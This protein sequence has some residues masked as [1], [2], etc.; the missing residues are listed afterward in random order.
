MTNKRHVE[1]PFSCELVVMLSYAISASVGILFVLHTY[2]IMNNYS[3]IECTRL[4]SNG[5]YR[6]LGY[7]RALRYTLGENPLLWLLPIAGPS[8]L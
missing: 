8:G 2:F 7:C 4:M 1:D 5:H 6:R 3:T